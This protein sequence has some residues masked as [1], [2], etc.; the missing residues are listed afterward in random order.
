MFGSFLILCSVAVTQTAALSKVSGTCFPGLLKIQKLRIVNENHVDQIE[1]IKAPTIQESFE[2]VREIYVGKVIREGIGAVVSN[3][4]PVLQLAHLT[5]A[6]IVGKDTRSSHGYQM[7]EYIKMGKRHPN[8]KNCDLGENIY[9]V[10]INISKKCTN[11]DL[12]SLEELGVFKNC[13]TVIIPILPSSKPRTCLKETIP[14]VQNFLQPSLQIAPM[15]NYRTDVCVVRRGGDMERRIASGIAN[16]TAIDEKHTLPI[17]QS[18]KE[19]GARI[20]LITQTKTA[21]VVLQKYNPDIFSNQEHLPLTFKRLSNCRCL[22]ISAGSS[23][24]LLATIISSPSFIVHTEPA[25]DFEFRFE[26]YA[27]H[28]LGERAV[29]IRSNRSKIIEKCLLRD[30]LSFFRTLLTNLKLN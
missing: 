2:N 7:T 16:Y 22:F 3:F 26:P 23:F 10:L 14:L 21:Q 20:V 29:S 11:Y 18:L 30:K 17:I 19:M 1:K 8:R 4:R 6:V 5:G 15:S 28:E 27:Y 25:P 13:N 24:A 12:N 9:D